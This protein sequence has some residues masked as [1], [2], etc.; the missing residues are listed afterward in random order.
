MN[1]RDVSVIDL[2]E[3]DSVCT[4]DGVD[5]QCYEAKICFSF[6]KATIKQLGGKKAVNMTIIVDKSQ[7]D[8][9]LTAR[10]RVG[11]WSRTTNRLMKQTELQIQ[12]SGEKCL[13]PVKVFL[14]NEMDD[15]LTPIDISIDFT[16]NEE[17]TEFD[18]NVSSI[19]SLLF[20]NINDRC[21]VRWS[22]SRLF[23][24]MAIAMF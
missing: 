18:A 14:S 9:Q 10:A 16:L 12:T 23:A 4:E 13:D 22:A 2:D 8:K 3:S 21:S 24:S 6:N 5:Y 19:I 1:G 11:G 15:K 17:T 7:S 20:S